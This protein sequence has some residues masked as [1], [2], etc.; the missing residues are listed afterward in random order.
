M[1]Q[2]KITR[3]SFLEACGA[4]G[5]AGALAACGGS[6][7]SETAA[8]STAA[9]STAASSTAS[10]EPTYIAAPYTI[11]DGDSV[12]SK[13]LDP[14]FYENDGGPTIGVTL[15]GVIEQDGMYFRDMNNNGKLDDFED[16]R[17]DPETRAKAFVKAM[18][19]EQMAALY[20]NDMAYSSA[21]TKKDD[22]VDANGEP[23]WENILPE[24]GANTYDTEATGAQFLLDTK[25]RAFVMRNNPET[26][27][28]VWFN[29]ML[30][31]VSEYDAVTTGEIAVPFIK[32]TNPIS[33]G[34][35]GKL[36]ITAAALGDG[37]TDVVY[38]YADHDRV[39]MD[40]IG[41]NAMYGPQIDLVTDPRWSR[42][43][44]T[45]GERT[46]TIADITTA[47]VDGYQQGTDGISKGS[48]ALIMKHFPGDGAAENGFES[49]YKAGEA[50]VYSTENSLE[51]YQLASFKAAI[52]ANVAGI[53]P[54]YSM[55][56]DDARTATQ[57]VNGEE[58]H[59][60]SVSNA[61]NKGV[62]TDLLR[63]N[64]GFKGYVN[65]DS[66]Y[67]EGTM[68]GLD[69]SKPEENIVMM[70][71]AGTDCGVYSAATPAMIVDAIDNGSLTREELET[72]TAR[73][74]TAMFQME[75]LD[76]PYKNLDE[77][78]AAASALSD[79]IAEEAHVA[80]QKS[81][82]L[83]KNE[84]TALPLAKEKTLYVEG[85]NDGK[86]DP[87]TTCADDLTTLGYTIVDDYKSADVAVLMVSPAALTMDT[88][89]MHVLD[90]VEDA[91]VPEYVDGKATGGTVEYT[92]VAEISRL[93][94]IADAVH[95]NG[96]TVVGSIN[97][98]SPWILTNLEPYCDAL[99]GVFD[100]SNVAIAEVLA[101]E[102]NP[103][104]KLPVTM[105]ADASVIAVNEVTEDGLTYEKC[106]S[107][108]DVPGY[109]KEQYM[110]AAVLSASPSGSYAYKDTSGN[111]Y[112][113]GFGLSY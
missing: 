35:P 54:G 81:V 66:H 30:E 7:S 102:Y 44:T 20:F 56:T 88:N 59:F 52:A 103:T 106:V 12:D 75:K 5:A 98:S 97:I 51:K 45:Y 46:D 22:V 109:E 11:A 108:N 60:E 67:G 42:N 38:N 63:D 57:V 29:N 33:N 43:N 107:P 77:S 78:V 96:G 104:G 100:T 15:V 74:L 65:S 82:V 112:W 3:R 73:R 92:S 68:H 41:V 40:S 84:N 14:V 61:F 17:L 31:Q 91:E 64:L 89:H 21:N 111:L 37:N 26:S 70:I 13:I 16:W 39:I 113:S 25:M 49:H 55:P 32:M 80:N 93:Q 95:A 4:L 27:V 23:V 9:S 79:T 72:A 76:N 10:G 53:M 2:H 85:F 101:G 1:K 87:M 62:I 19:T 8:S 90:L 83:M 58:F 34:Y 69:T 6:S 71:K 18:T 105:V 47:L 50:R 86:G 94:K 48:I 24:K 36:G 28:G 99:I 110:D